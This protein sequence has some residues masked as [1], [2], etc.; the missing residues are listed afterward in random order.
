VAYQ[1]W[2]QRAV[3]KKHKNRGCIFKQREKPD[4]I[5]STNIGILG[6]ILLENNSKYR[7][8]MDPEM[9]ARGLSI[10]QLEK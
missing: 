5:G 3:T 7:Q 10:Q 6:D 1:A 8:L 4:M 2:A 9:D